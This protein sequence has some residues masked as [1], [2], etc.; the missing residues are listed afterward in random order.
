MT[1]KIFTPRD[2][3]AALLDLGK[4]IDGCL[5]AATPGSGKTVVGLTLADYL[6][7]NDFG[8]GI[9]RT[10]V[11]APKMV[12][13]NVWH[14]E[15]QGWAHLRHLNVRVLT[16]EDFAYRQ[17][18]EWHCVD[19][20]GSARVVLDREAT[21]EDRAHIARLQRT[22]W[23]CPGEGYKGVARID[24]LTA[25]QADLD[26][27]AERRAEGL[28]VEVQVGTVI[29]KRILE[30]ADPA[31]V[32][33]QILAYPET[34]VTVSR[35]HLY[36]LALVMKSK[37]PFQLVIADESTSYANPSSNR[38]KALRAM[39]LNK[40]IK[41]VVLLTGT[42]FSRSAEQLRSQM[43]LV[44]GG[45]RLGGPRELT[46]FRTTYMEPDARN[47]QRVF[48]WKLRP[49]MRQPLWDKISD[50]A[51]SVKADGWRKVGEARRVE[52][53]VT[54]PPEAQAYYDEMEEKN[55]ITVDEDVVAVNAAVLAGKLLQI[56]SGT[57]KG[58]S[59]KAN[60]IHEVK[61]D[62]LEELVEEIDGPVVVAYW[63]VEN[64]ARLKKRFKKGKSIKEAG[65][66][67]GF[68]KGKFDVLFVHPQSA[69]HGINGLQWRTNRMII[70]D[71]FHSLE[72][73]I[74]T[75]ARLDR[76]GQEKQ[77]VIDVIEAA[78]TLDQAIPKLWDKRA[79]EQNSLMDALLWRRQVARVNNLSV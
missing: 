35:D 13:E 29:R 56:A 58:E 17:R 74:Q 21:D 25:T 77:V 46:K 22:V 73:A 12:A 7:H 67:D 33:D 41:R 50:V 8:S 53:L 14:R 30:A 54:L 18:V 4:R 31:A 37:W 5:M 62:F 51:M 6:M 68:I 3:Q 65:A 52:R 47:D 78:G 27:L 75:I 36:T 49:E 69:G 44:D 16:A 32:R 57:V 11:V 42:P 23:S 55:L 71:P 24:P 34:I 20:L 79:D 59:G 48:S 76:S 40:R 10:L 9:K 15:V 26:L 28:A 38:S 70:L 43:L 64:L 19:E 45:I 66:L 63:W 1:V 2:Y 72:L 60:P 39:R 61:L